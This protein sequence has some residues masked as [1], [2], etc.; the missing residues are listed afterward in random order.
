M[1]LKILDAQDW[2]P[3]HLNYPVGYHPTTPCKKEDTSFRTFDGSF[4]YDESTHRMMF[5]PLSLR[6]MDYAHTHFGSEGLCRTTNVD[7]DMQEVNT[8]RICT[9]IPT[10]EYVAD[11]SVPPKQRPSPATIYNQEYCAESSR[12]VPFSY[13][14]TTREG[15]RAALSM[16]G[17]PFY[18]HGKTTDDASFLNNSYRNL[19]IFAGYDDDGDGF[20]DKCTHPDLPTTP[21]S[22]DDDC[23]AEYRCHQVGNICV[24]RWVTCVVA[25]VCIFF[26]VMLCVLQEHKHLQ[27][28]PRLIGSLLVLRPL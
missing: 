19:G 2:W 9:R 5:E 27:R 25:S 12:D 13:K 6:D 26:N 17:I 10:S 14:G 15:W 23:H 18:V 8:A 16:G 20:G 22:T 7:L 3:E 28:Q 4:Y 1:M 24:K 21:C 11:P